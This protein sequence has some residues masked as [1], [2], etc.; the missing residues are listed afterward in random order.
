MRELLSSRKSS[1]S[2]DE[3]AV[4]SQNESMASA[5]ALKMCAVIKGE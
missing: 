5:S 1:S 3:P 2:M 4:V